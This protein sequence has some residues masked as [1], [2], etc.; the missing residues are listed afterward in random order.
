MNKEIKIIPNKWYTLN[1]IVILAH[2]GIFPSR[3][4]THIK[5]LLHIRKLKGVNIGVKSLE[6]WR[7]SG[8]ELIN[9]MNGESN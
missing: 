8:K 7:V 9:F 2:N 5:R 6:H 4:K 3:S 1:Q